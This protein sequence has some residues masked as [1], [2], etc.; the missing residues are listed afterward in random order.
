MNSVHDCELKALTK[1]LESNCKALQNYCNAS[2]KTQ[3]SFK[4]SKIIAC[5]F[6][7]RKQVSTCLK[8]DAIKQK[9]FKTQTSLN[10]QVPKAGT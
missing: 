3:T 8:Y 1:H 5:F 2:L 9:H 10:L 7:K 4:T 6:T